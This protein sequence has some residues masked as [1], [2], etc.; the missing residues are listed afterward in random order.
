MCSTIVALV[1]PNIISQFAGP[2]YSDHNTFVT[3]K[4]EQNNSQNGFVMDVKATTYTCDK[5]V[6]TWRITAN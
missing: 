1:P 2:A 5:L 3:I 6:Y 4:A